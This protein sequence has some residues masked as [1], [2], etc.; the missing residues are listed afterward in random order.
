LAVAI[1]CIVEPNSVGKEIYTD[2]N[3]TGPYLL[4][5]RVKGRGGQHFLEGFTDGEK[6]AG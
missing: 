2:G 4:E 1:A 6:K 5:N 3:L